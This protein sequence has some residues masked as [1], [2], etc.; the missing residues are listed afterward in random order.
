MSLCWWCCHDVGNSRIGVPT[1]R[2]IERPRRP[3]V[4]FFMVSITPPLPIE[5]EITKY[6]LEGQ[7]CTFECARAYIISNGNDYLCQNKL[8]RLNSMRR[9]SF[10]DKGIEPKD[11]PKFKSAPTWKTLK[12]FGG[13]I[14][15][16]E[17]RSDD[18]EWVIQPTGFI[19][20]APNV[21]KRRQHIAEKSTWKEKQELISKST[22]SSEQLKIK[23]SKPRTTATGFGDISSTLGIK[24]IVKD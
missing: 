11:I 4:P 6:E 5:E 15:Y 22:K 23:R 24:V 3:Y 9:K 1:E 21:L 7:F 17:F 10:K 12:Q 18:E 13:T 19:F 2:I 20:N 14:T 16:E 8:Q